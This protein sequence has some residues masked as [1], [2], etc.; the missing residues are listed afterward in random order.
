MRC[1]QAREKF[2]LV[3]CTEVQ[4]TPTAHGVSQR[5]RWEQKQQ[6]DYLPQ[7]A[8]QSKCRRGNSILLATRFAALKLALDACK[9]K[10]LSGR[11][12]L[13]GECCICVFLGLPSSTLATPLG[14]GLGCTEP[15]LL[16]WPGTGTPCHVTLSDAGDLC[17]T[18]MLTCQVTQGSDSSLYLRAKSTLISCTQDL[19]P[20]SP[21]PGRQL[22][23]GPCQEC[24]FYGLLSLVWVR[25]TLC[26]P[27]IT[28]P[29]LSTPLRGPT[30][31]PP[32]VSSVNSAL[33]TFGRPL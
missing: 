14:L 18:F 19:K 32:N 2:I 31:A 25:Y 9:E 13:M 29:E 6:T 1:L 3:W 20:S 10:A 23:L 8:K 17:V 30:S 24:S 11:A 16:H 12:R 22:Y 5:V 26:T 21:P 7:R 4:N 15:A 27:P 28:L 33:L